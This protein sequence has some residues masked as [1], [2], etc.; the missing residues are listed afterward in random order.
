MAKFAFIGDKRIEYKDVFTT[1]SNSIRAQ[2]QR[3][4]REALLD[5]NLREEFLL[6]CEHY[7]LISLLDEIREC[8]YSFPKEPFYQSSYGELGIRVNLKHIE[9]RSLDGKYLSHQTLRFSKE[10]QIFYTN[11]S[12]FKEDKPSFI[13]KVESEWEGEK[14]FPLTD[15]EEDGIVLR[16]KI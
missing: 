1:R 3:Y 8:D 16:K 13:P 14:I 5:K 15:Y 12:P 2:F 11:Y 4:G 7:L 6:S 9:L 10:K